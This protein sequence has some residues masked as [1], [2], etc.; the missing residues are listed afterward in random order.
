MKQVVKQKSKRRRAVSPLDKKVKAN[1][2]GKK[3]QFIIF[4]ACSMLALVLCLVTLV[5]TVK[6]IEKDSSA[7]QTVYEAESKTFLKGEKEELISYVSELSKYTQDNK[8]VKVNSYTD[9]SIDDSGIIVNGESGSKDAKLFAFLKNQLIGSVDALYKEDSTGVF[10]TVYKGM[11]LKT[12]AFPEKTEHSFSQGM[13][14]E[15]GAPAL[16][17]EGNLIDS[18]YY[19]ITFTV[20]GDQLSYDEK[21]TFEMIA[22]EEIEA[23]VKKSISSV[24]SI[25]SLES[26]AEDFS[27]SFKI[28][29]L[30]DEISALEIKRIY[31]ISMDVDFIN[32]LQSFGNKAIEF[33]YAVSHKYDYFYAGV[34]LSQKE[35][36]INGKDEAVLSVNA[37]IEND[38]EYEIE[39]I[40]SDESI[41]T[42]DEMGYIK[43]VKSSDEPVTVTVKLTYLGQIFTD[44]CKVYVDFNE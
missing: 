29:R 41:V 15:N 6:S 33:K 27:V 5:V 23:E 44:E 37:V 3:K 30:T 38:S 1:E 21:Q 8:F 12:M 17:D 43:A 11:P 4:G 14:D 35:I 32:E 22:S 2:Q 31:N 13:T 10:G 20:N 42:V 16:D 24:C 34:I 39:F 25:N 19:F 7:Q 40:S 28:N 18:D 36:T 9:I 26:S